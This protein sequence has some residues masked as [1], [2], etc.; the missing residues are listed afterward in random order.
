VEGAV[1]GGGGDAQAVPRGDDLR[2][3]N[4][5]IRDENAQMRNE[6]AVMMT[7]MRALAEAQGADRRGPAHGQALPEAAQ[8]VQMAQNTQEL[9]L[10][11]PVLFYRRCK[12]GKSIPPNAF[13]MELEARQTRHGWEPSMLLR[14]VKSCL[15]G[16]AALW[17]EGC[18]LSY[19][20]EE[21]QGPAENY[22][23]F[24]VSFKQHYGIGGATN[25]LCWADTFRQRSDEDIREYFFRSTAEL[26]N[27]LKESAK[28][29]F[30]KIYT[31]MDLGPDVNNML[32]RIRSRRAL[33]ENVG[34]DV[35]LH[36][37][38]DQ[39][40]REQTERSTRAAKLELAKNFH[41][42]LTSQ[43]IMQGLSKDGART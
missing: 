13:L 14:F 4:S 17:W 29:L 39:C 20:D 42:F 31:P 8:G 24:K 6:I 5:Q 38:T 3:E 43:A 15:R 40:V 36:Q 41:T 12:D 18:I 16:E 35:V 7:N 27:H 2:E 22:V 28:L 26:A 10:T 33:G 34:R 30:G 25:N 9:L 21:D 1:G 11:T 37:E 19:G 23:A 32:A